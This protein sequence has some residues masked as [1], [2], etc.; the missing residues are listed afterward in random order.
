[1]SNAHAYRL[2]IFKELRDTGRCLLRFAL[3]SAQKEDYG[4]LLK[5][6][7][8]V[9]FFTSFRWPLIDFQTARLSETFKC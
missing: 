3:L 2:L 9:N 8:A 1:P 7:Q 6:C 4:L 5:P